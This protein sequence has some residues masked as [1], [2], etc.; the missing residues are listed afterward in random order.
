MKRYDIIYADPAWKYGGGKGKNSK[1]WGNSLS[2]Y[3]CMKLQDMM[4]LPI[5]NMGKENSALFM[6]VTLPMLQEGMDLMKAWGY[7]YKTTAFVWNKVYT[8]GKPYCGMGYWTRS[9]SEICIL[10][11]KGKMERQST[12]VYQVINCEVGKHSVKPKEGRERIVELIGDLPRVEL[13]SRDNSNGWDAWGNEV[14]DSIDLRE[15]Y[16]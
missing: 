5:N 3:D 16:T 10:G 2:S 1:K 8:S 13:F 6:W 4:D 15:Y 11:F 9:G 12:S 14:E 7:K